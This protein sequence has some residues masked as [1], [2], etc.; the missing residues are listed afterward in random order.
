MFEQEGYIIKGDII[1]LFHFS[2]DS[3]DDKPLEDMVMVL[4]NLFYFLVS[5]NS[6][7]SNFAMTLK[8]IPSIPNKDTIVQP[9]VM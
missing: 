9:V 1:N 8:L 3:V 2:P 4:E 5:T 6:F 7:Y